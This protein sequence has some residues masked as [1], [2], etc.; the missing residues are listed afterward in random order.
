[1]HKAP[2][3]A[4]LALA[5]PALPA[6]AISGAAPTVDAQTQVTW[7]TVTAV[8]RCGRELNVGLLTPS[9]GRTFALRPQTVALRDGNARWL[10]WVDGLRPGDRVRVFFQTDRAGAADPVEFTDLSR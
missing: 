4:A 1:M 6:R 2:L 7:G 5:L 3:L 8:Q 10:G 9:G